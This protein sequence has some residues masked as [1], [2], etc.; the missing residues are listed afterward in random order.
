MVNSRQPEKKGSSRVR[1]DTNVFLSSN[2]NMFKPTQF[3]KIEG[4]KIVLTLKFPM[5]LTLK[6]S[7]SLTKLPSSLPFVLFLC[8]LPLKLFFFFYWVAIF[9]LLMYCTFASVALLVAS[10]SL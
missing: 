3:R 4:Y 7:I 10:C 5:D 2:P 6:A 1:T 8:P 9:A